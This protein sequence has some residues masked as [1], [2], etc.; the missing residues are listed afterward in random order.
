MGSNENHYSAYTYEIDENDFIVE[1]GKTKKQTIRFNKIYVNQV[2]MRK[3]VF[4]DMIM[5]YEEYKK[6][7]QKEQYHNRMTMTIEL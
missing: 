3:M 4:S 6:L 7:E 1:T 2:P 5:N